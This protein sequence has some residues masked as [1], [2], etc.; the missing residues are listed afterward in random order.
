MLDLKPEWQNIQDL[1]VSKASLKVGE[2]LDDDA[3]HVCTM[4][5]LRTSN[6]FRAINWLL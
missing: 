1:S 4:F 5:Y 6:D 3:W 2:A